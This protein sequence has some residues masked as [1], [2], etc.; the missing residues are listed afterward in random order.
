LLAPLD[1]LGTVE[2]WVVGLGHDYRL[3]KEL[4]LHIVQ[5][6]RLREGLDVVVVGEGRQ[7]RE[8]AKV[9]VGVQLV[10]LSMDSQCSL[11]GK[12]RVVH[13]VAQVRLTS[14]D[15]L[16]ELE[17]EQMV[18]AEEVV[19]H[20]RYLCRPVDRSLFETVGEASCYAKVPEL[21]VEGESVVVEALVL[22]AEIAIRIIS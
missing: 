21:A 12:I 13:R 10:L 20:E 3:V 15:K 14:H 4:L 2:Q 6:G 7:S 22:E 17:M 16:G 11:G 19:V 5:G 18:K 1:R 8:A 9:F